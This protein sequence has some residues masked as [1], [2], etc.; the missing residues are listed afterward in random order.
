MAAHQ[1]QLRKGCTR[2]CRCSSGRPG[3]RPAR[4]RARGPPCARHPRAHFPASQKP[5][6]RRC[7]WNNRDQ[8]GHP[9]LH[10][11]PVSEGS[12]GAGPPHVWLAQ[13]QRRTHVPCVVPAMRP[14]P[15]AIHVPVPLS[16][17]CRLWVR[18]DGTYFRCGA[19][20]VAPRVVVTAAHVSWATRQHGACP[21]RP[22]VAPPHPGPPSP[23]ALRS[24]LWVT[25]GARPPM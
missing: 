16:C 7:L 12:Y 18:P 4:R 1:D 10:G 5:H 8:P 14:G 24:A 17:P 25:T 15:A 21:C 11:C 23:P 19:T 9:P 13:R 20:L 3:P 2:P 22:H 6:A